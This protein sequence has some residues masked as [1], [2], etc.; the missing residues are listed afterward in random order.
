[1]NISRSIRRLE[2]G[3]TLSFPLWHLSSVRTIASKF[4]RTE[5]ILTSCW[6]ADEKVHVRRLAPEEKGQKRGPASR[7][8]FDGMKVGECRMFERA[9]RRS[10]AVIVSK[11]RRMGWKIS[12][13]WDGTTGIV[14]RL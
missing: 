11:R 8:D 14:W 5:G 12:L 13:S 7:Y 9:N 2:E 1:M 10:L 3:E 6:V 4:K